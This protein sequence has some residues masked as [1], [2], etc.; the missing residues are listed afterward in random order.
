MVQL[1]QATIDAINHDVAPHTVALSP[2]LLL[3]LGNLF[4]LIAPILI[5]VLQDFAATGVTPT[6]AQVFAKASELTG[7]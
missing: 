6:A 3:T 5:K 4:Q 2:G 7:S 1:S